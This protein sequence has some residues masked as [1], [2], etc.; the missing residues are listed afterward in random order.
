MKR[1]LRVVLLS[2][3]L[4][5]VLVVGLANLMGDGEPLPP[6]DP[7]L[8]ITLPDGREEPL[9]DLLER[10]AQE[11]ATSAAEPEAAVDEEAAAAGDPP[12]DDDDPLL[13]RMDE[14]G[15]V[16]VS[17]RWPPPVDPTDVFSL[18]FHAF[19][20]HRDEEALALLQS[21]PEDH[22]RYADAQ[23]RIGWDLLTNRMGRPA[24]G[25]A[26]ANRSLDADPLSG[27]AWQD[28]SR[29]YL[30]TLGIPWDP[31]QNRIREP[32]EGKR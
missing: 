6:P 3:L 27:E 29:V 11:A 8:V 21:V 17:F 9:G 25:L 23:R 16:R 13:A 14:E 24:A 32:G 20:E 28:A 2:V 5:L 19:L 30:A 10:L 4:L 15:V 18:G 12:R 1:A 7:A 22:P 26:Y 31:V